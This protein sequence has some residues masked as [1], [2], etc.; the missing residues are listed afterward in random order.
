MDN[1]VLLLLY[2]LVL[3]HYKN[4]ESLQLNLMNFFPLRDKSSTND[5]NVLKDSYKI[6]NNLEKIEFI[7]YETYQKRIKI[8]LSWLFTTGFGKIISKLVKVDGLDFVI[9][10]SFGLIKIKET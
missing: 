6:F 8:M 5:I 2:L 1:C 4:L 10:E 7:N 3:M 9:I